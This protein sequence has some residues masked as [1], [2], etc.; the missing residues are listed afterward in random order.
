MTAPDG[1]WTTDTA[2][3]FGEVLRAA[4][5]A[6]APL[7]FDGHNVGASVELWAG[8]SVAVGLPGTGTVWSAWRAVL[9]GPGMASVGQYEWEIE[10]LAG[11]G[12]NPAFIFFV[13]I[14]APNDATDFNS[15]NVY[16]WHSTG[17]LDGRSHFNKA[18]GADVPVDAVYVGNTRLGDRL[19]FMYDGVRGDVALAVNG[20]AV[21][22]IIRGA[23]A[24]AGDDACATIHAGFFL[25]CATKVRLVSFGRKAAPVLLAAAAADGEE[26][27]DAM[28]G[29]PDAWRAPP[30]PARFDG[31][32]VGASVAL[33]SE[34]EGEGEAAGGGPRTLAL[35]LPGTGAVWSAWRAMLAGPESGMRVGRYVW[36]MEPLD[37]PGGALPF[38]AFLSVGAPSDG[39]DCN[40][41]NVFGWHS[42][43]RA[44]FAH[45]RGVPVPVTIT[46]PLAARDRLM[47]WYDAT[48]GDLS[49]FVNGF[50]VGAIIQGAV[51]EGGAGVYAG[52]FLDCGTKVRLLS[53]STQPE[54]TGTPGEVLP[55]P[56]PG[57]EDDGWGDD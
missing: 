15:P 52:F 1:G 13:S 46:G 47:F 14:G 19:R 41:P 44:G 37:G 2:R 7:V 8:A 17:S 4:R 3:V 35:G 5:E 33:S 42:L 23:R 11:P 30:A 12:D 24:G 36:E 28:E 49:L 25:D 48:T 31:D 56:Q 6:P 18:R 40:S 57:D 9:A 20:A 10:A 21:G 26:D 27:T 39:T 34:G 29:D 22:T 55:W 50:H 32:N 43:G 38:I 45:A 51:P 54:G 16:G 53:Y